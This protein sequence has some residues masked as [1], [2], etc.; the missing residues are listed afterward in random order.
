LAYGRCQVSLKPSAVVLACPQRWE[1]SHPEDLRT[2]VP[3]GKLTG[4]EDSRDRVALGTGR[5]G[6]SRRAQ[7]L[8]VEYYFIEDESPTVI[9]QTPQNTQFLEPLSW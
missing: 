8:D 9:E 7:E 4:S 6:L 2:G 3:T 1:S 5:V